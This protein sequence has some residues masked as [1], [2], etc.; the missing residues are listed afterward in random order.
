MSLTSLTL[1]R[2][3]QKKIK[4][5]LFIPKF[6]V[7]FLLATVGWVLTSALCFY[8]Q[9][10]VFDFPETTP[11][12]GENI[13]NPYQEVKGQVIK[14]N[15]HAHSKA[16]GGLTNGHNSSEELLDSYQKKGYAFAGI[17]NYFATDPLNKNF[18]VY[19]HGINLMKSHKLAINPSSVEYFDYPLFQNLSQKQDIINRL[20]DNDA[21]VALAHPNFMKGHSTED[22][23]Q[24]TGYHFTEVL[25]HY[26]TSEEEW[27]AALKTGKLS[28]ILANDDTHDIHNEPTH[29]IWNEIY[30]T[31][32]GN[33]QMT[34]SL[35][36]G[37]NYGINTKNGINDLSIKQLKVIGDS[38]HFDFGSKAIVIKV[39]LD[40]EVF[41]TLQQSEGAIFFPKNSQYM[42]LV[43]E[44]EESSLFTNPLVRYSDKKPGLVSHI[45][46]VINYPKTYFHRTLF[47][48]A[49]AL[50]IMWLTGFRPKMTGG[51]FRLKRRQPVYS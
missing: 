21:L 6:I 50:M 19:E 2:S 45:S 25:N 42:R 5:L 15:F 24:L 32:P 29:K 35:L 40:G 12:G 16:W 28:W 22:M 37:K 27:D 41:Q 44:S 9:T 1:D 38:V 8:T 49:I 39:I 10:T 4:F 13:H 17:S 36:E 30:V 34:K 46:P 47:Y 23:K 3:L 18:A 20:R 7:K 43:A 33:N 11:F 26:R 14:A 31:L 51:G 48:L